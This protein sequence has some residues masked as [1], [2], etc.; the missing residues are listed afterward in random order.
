MNFDE[1]ARVLSAIDLGNQRRTYR[2][3]P[4]HAGNGGPGKRSI[5]STSEGNMET[6][7][8]HV[9]LASTQLLRNPCRLI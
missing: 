5:V 2:R 6:G 4:A 9:M 8:A 7:D 1:F 3:I